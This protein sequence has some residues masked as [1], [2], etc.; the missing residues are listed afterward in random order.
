MKWVSKLFFSMVG[1]KRNSCSRSTSGV[2]QSRVLSTSMANVAA[3]STSGFVTEKKQLL[4]K[5]KVTDFVKELRQ[6]KTGLLAF[7]KEQVSSGAHL[8]FFTLDSRQAFWEQCIQTAELEDLVAAL[9][10]KYISILERCFKGR[11]KYARLQIEWME[12]VRA[13]QHDHDRPQEEATSRWADLLETIPNPSTAT[14]SILSCASRA[15]FMYCQQTIVNVKE[16]VETSEEV[17]EELGPLEEAGL[18]TDEASLYR[19]GGFALHTVLK[20]STSP[21]I[22]SVLTAIRMPLAEK[23]DL[24]SNIIYLNRGGMTFMRKDM[25]GYLSL[26]WKSSCY[27]LSILTWP[28]VLIQVHERLRQRSTKDFIRKHGANA[29]KVSIQHELLV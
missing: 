14:S 3:T 18:T 15:V 23:I 20:A 1:I 21:A 10:E 5:K 11:E 4:S 16:G 22:V 8:H 7:V 12:S 17:A 29:M 13:A 25:L 9:F 2:L 6:R 28:S 19:L 27:I 24:P 26:V